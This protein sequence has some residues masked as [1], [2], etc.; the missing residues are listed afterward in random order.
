MNQIVDG[1]RVA[2]PYTLHARATTKDGEP[3]AVEI[4]GVMLLHFDGALIASRLDV[5]DALTYLRQVGQA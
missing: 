4:R 1:E 5:W 3:V 2:A